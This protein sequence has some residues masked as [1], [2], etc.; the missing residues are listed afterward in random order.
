MLLTIEA[1]SLPCSHCRRSSNRLGAVGPAAA[2]MPWHA[3]QVSVNF[4][5][6]GLPRPPPRPPPCA[7]GCCA[8]GGCCAA[9]DVTRRAA[10]PSINEIDFINA[11]LL[12]RPDVSVRCAAAAEIEHGARG[13]RVFP[14]NQPRDQRGELL[15]LHEAPAR[16]LR[17]HVVDVLLRGLLENAGPRRRRGNAVD[18]DVLPRELLPQRLR[19]RDHTRL[20]GAVPGRVRIALLTRNR[21]D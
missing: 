14:G 15:D 21:R 5:A 7:G 6:V 10:A 13:E 17:Q 20:R 11:L 3:A 19:Q 8:G 9:I 4:V 12:L 1:S 16:N 2:L 18:R